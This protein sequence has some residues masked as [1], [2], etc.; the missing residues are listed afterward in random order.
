M[1]V[2]RLVNPAMALVIPFLKQRARKKIG[3]G[4][5]AYGTGKRP[6][7]LWKMNRLK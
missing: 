2:G 4:G 6:A 3:A 5:R 7:S 1:D